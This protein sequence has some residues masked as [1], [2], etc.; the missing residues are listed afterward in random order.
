[1]IIAN[2]RMQE[3]ASF[4]FEE[5]LNKPKD[6]TFDLNSP[7]TYCRICGEIFQTP[8]DREKNQTKSDTFYNSV[9]R[10]AWSMS[11]AKTHTDREHLQLAISGLWVT[12]DA[13][14]KLEGFGIH[15]IGS[16]IL[17]KSVEAALREAPNTPQNDVEGSR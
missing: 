4:R 5:N 14:Y 9:R 11:H 17:S 13:A 2:T 8:Q 16:A 1:M 15:A 12:P 7:H 6:L 10:K 3:A